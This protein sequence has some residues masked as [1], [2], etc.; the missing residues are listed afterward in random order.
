MPTM[1]S[2]QLLTTK[3]LATITATV[4]IIK[5]QTYAKSIRMISQMV[6]SDLPWYQF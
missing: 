3:A 2:T 4:E 5:I 1:T 6:S